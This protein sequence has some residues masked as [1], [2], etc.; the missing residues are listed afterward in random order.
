ML[1]VG[2]EPRFGLLHGVGGRLPVLRR[3]AGDGDTGG[4]QQGECAEP[5]S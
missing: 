2:V 3:L 5:D 1:R 4:S